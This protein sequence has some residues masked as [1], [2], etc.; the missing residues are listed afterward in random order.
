MAFFWSVVHASLQMVGNHVARTGCT[1]IIEVIVSVNPIL[2]LVV[3]VDSLG[4]GQ[5]LFGREVKHLLV[6]ATSVRG[7]LCAESF[8]GF[9][10]HFIV[11]KSEYETQ[12]EIGFV[13]REHAIVHGQVCSARQI[14]IPD[15]GVS[16]NAIHLFMGLTGEQG[17]THGVHIL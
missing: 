6:H 5:F 11:G 14:L 8:E 2:W 3:G 1:I 16:V 10:A 7:V 9:D 17:Y 12:H 15:G 4:D 13:K